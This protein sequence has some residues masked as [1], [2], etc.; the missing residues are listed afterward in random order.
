MQVAYLVD[1]GLFDTGINDFTE[2]REQD[3]QRL[4]GNKL[5]DLK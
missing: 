5:I 2:L 1:H 3:A 4:L